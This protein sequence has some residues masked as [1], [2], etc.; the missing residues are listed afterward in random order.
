[1][2]AQPY[3]PRAPEASLGL[4][5]EHA[6]DR[7]RGV[8]RSEARPKSLCPQRAGPATGCRGRRVR[9]DA[10]QFRS[11]CF[12]KRTRRLPLMGS[13]G[14]RL[15]GFRFDGSLC[16]PPC[17]LFL[18]RCAKANQRFSQC[19]HSARELAA[20][21][22][23]MQRQIARSGAS[24]Q[25]ISRAI[26]LCCV[27][28]QI[29][30]GRANAGSGVA[31]PRMCRCRGFPASIRRALPTAV[32]IDSPAMAAGCAHC[33]PFARN[34]RGAA[35]RPRARMRAECAC[36]GRARVVSETKAGVAFATPARVRD[37]G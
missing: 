19:Q 28:E 2:Q 23:A 5:T 25:C 26:P 1:M 6:G 13:A 34:L 10:W 22:L 32:R 3:R 7:A 12:S 9:D 21:R 24:K 35:R 30:A 4:K 11:A 15:P 33:A 29:A 37:R 31:R 14:R 20:R 17:V 18:T 36:C 27:S 16:S 8:A